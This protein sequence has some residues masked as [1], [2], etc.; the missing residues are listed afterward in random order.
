MLAGR[1][2]TKKRI[3]TRATALFEAVT[4]ESPVKELTTRRLTPAD[5]PQGVALTADAGWNQIDADWR[6]MLAL[7]DGLGFVAGDGTLVATAIVLPYPEPAPARTQKFGWISMVLVSPSWQ[8][9]GLARWMLQR[10]IGALQGA[11][12][13]PMLD[14]TPAGREVYRKL[15]FVEG[16]EIQRLEAPR[17]SGISLEMSGGRLYV[18]MFEDR[19]ADAAWF[20]RSIFGADRT[21]LI[22]AIRKRDLPAYI[23]ERDGAVDGIAMLREGRRA[24][25]LGPVLAT[26]PGIAAQI[27]SPFGMYTRDRPVFMDVPVHQTAFI[28]ALTAAGFKLQR[29]LTR[30]YLGAKAPGAMPE[31]CFGIAGPELG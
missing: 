26:E 30:M 31:R 29:K 13:M 8:R 5:I 15:G 12:Y 17:L 6:M 18:P 16:M 2:L 7:G 4:F 9:R 28:A 27:L 21:G 24:F 19:V 10:C 25:H 23:A 14:A 20:D 22:A 11:G 3:T 1:A